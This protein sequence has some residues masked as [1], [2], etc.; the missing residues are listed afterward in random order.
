[1]HF[2]TYF[3]LDSIEDTIE[4]VTAGHPQVLSMI[5]ETVKMTKDMSFENPYEKHA[6]ILEEVLQEVRNP[7][8]WCLSLI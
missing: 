1:M 5:E 8:C 3:T 7:G 6:E 4:E 2:L